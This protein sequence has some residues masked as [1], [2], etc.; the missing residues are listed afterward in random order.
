MKPLEI[1]VLRAQHE[2]HDLEAER[3]HVS[4]GGDVVT[5]HM[6]DGETVVLSRLE[7]EDAMRGEAA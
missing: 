5:L 7:L 6:Q 3:A 1:T 2:T 4:A